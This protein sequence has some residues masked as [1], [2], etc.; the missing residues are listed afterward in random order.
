MYAKRRYLMFRTANQLLSEEGY[1]LLYINDITSE[2]WLEKKQ[3][4]TSYVIR[5]SLEQFD[6]K[7]RL[8]EDMGRVLQRLHTF[9]GQLRGRTVNVYNIYIADFPPVDSWEQLKKPILWKKGKPVVLQTYYITDE[10]QG[11]ELSR[12][13]R[14]ISIHIEPP[15]YTEHIEEESYNFE[16]QVKQEHQKRQKELQQV[17]NYQKPLFTYILLI[18]NILMFAILEWN[19]GSTSIQTL[20]QYGAKYNPGILDGEWWRIVT[21]MFLHIGILHLMM[22]MLALYHLGTA[23]ERMF[24]RFRFLFIYFASGTFGGLA[25]FTLNPQ[26]AAGASGAIF[27]L[28]GAM[29]FFGLIYKRLFIQT[30]GKNILFVIVLNIILG[31][32]VPQIDNGAHIGGLIGGFIASAVVWMPAKKNLWAQLLAS[33]VLI[34]SLFGLAIYG[35]HSPAQESASILLHEAQEAVQ[36]ENYEEVL[37]ITNKALK[38]PEAMEAELLFIRSYASIKLGDTEK[39]IQDLEK[40]IELQPDMAEA[41]YNLALLYAETN[42]RKKALQHAKE[43]NRLKPNNADFES[44]LQRLEAEG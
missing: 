39:G 24:G 20:I 32:S 18:L 3:K 17:F 5:F 28:F 4:Q 25:S 44:F 22:N 19:G 12:F 7:N 42:K 36:K 2:L 6:W 29:L 14:D 1:N 9:K 10:N 23:V 11:E 30:I 33:F 13:A 26:V 37:T 38:K 15:L 21:S 41:H 31:L 16:K 43:A 40:V 35:L 8:K 27:G 34:S